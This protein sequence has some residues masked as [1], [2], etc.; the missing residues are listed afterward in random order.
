MKDVQGNSGRDH[1]F[2]QLTPILLLLL[3]FVIVFEPA[4]ETMVPGHA[5]FRQ[6]FGDHFLLRFACG[7]LVFY[8]LVLWGEC[9]RLN[10]GLT[11]VLKA[12]R[13]AL[14]KAGAGDSGMSARLDAIRML[15]AAMQSDDLA[16]RAKSRANL[17]R[18]VGQDL[19]DDPLAWRNWLDQQPAQSPPS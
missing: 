5:W 18:L 7:L 6:Q 3:L 10:N 14:V 1:W 13:E 19:G 11:A 15:V 8:V 9:I 4:V 17:V 12:M 2:R 16:I